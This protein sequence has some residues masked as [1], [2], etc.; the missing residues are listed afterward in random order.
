VALEVMGRQRTKKNKAS[1][2]NADR[3]IGFRLIIEYPIKGFLVG[4][5]LFYENWST[6]TLRK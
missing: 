2:K 6:A 1:R 4:I 5:Y 3:T